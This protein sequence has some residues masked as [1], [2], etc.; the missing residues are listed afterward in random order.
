MSKIITRLF[1]HFSD[2]E[3]AVGELERVGVPHG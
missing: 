1:D 3:R 2:A